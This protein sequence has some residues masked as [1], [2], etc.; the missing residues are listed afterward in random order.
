MSVYCSLN[1][2][3]SYPL[4][5]FILIISVSIVFWPSFVD[6]KKIQK[7]GQNITFKRAELTLI[8]D[9]G[10]EKG[11]LLILKNTGNET[12]KT[13]S[14]ELY[15][16][17]KIYGKVSN[18]PSQ[19]GLYDKIKPDR[20]ITIRAGNVC[21]NTDFITLKTFSNESGEIFFQYNSTIICPENSG[22]MSK[23]VGRKS[24]IPS[25]G[26]V[27]LALIGDC[28]NPS[29]CL[30]V[31]ENTENKT[32]STENIILLRDGEL[33]KNLDK[34]PNDQGTTFSKISPKKVLFLRAKDICKKTEM[35]SAEVRTFDNNS[36]GIIYKD[37]ILCP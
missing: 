2:R 35:V 26:R 33:Y 10:N 1:S 37:N 14:L 16:K 34:I 19:Y 24:N 9:C 22:Y 20:I 3:W 11:C 30:L 31:V 36:L 5:I 7:S 6:E 17:G 29:G 25:I 28:N 32:I 23:N 13:S 12:V 8:G 15:K 21:K 18:F 27:N 4:L